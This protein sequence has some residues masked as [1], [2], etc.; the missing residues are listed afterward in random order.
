MAT[1]PLNGDGV[2]R[3]RKGGFS[4]N[5]DNKDHVAE[6]VT[7]EEITETVWGKTPTGTGELCNGRVEDCCI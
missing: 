3:Q 1:A 5:T 7:T 2:L 4:V 6:P